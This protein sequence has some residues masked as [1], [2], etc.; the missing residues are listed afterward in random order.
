MTEQ[1]IEIYDWSADVFVYGPRSDDE[2]S[3]EPKDDGVEVSV[4]A[5]GGYGYGTYPHGAR[6]R[7][8]W[9]EWDRILTHVHRGRAA[10]D[11]DVSPSG[12]SGTER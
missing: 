7:F 5:D 8:S 9:A 10:L 6:W 4:M 3:L 1:R 12:S 2:L 11:A